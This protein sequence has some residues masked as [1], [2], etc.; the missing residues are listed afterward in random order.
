MLIERRIDNRLTKSGF[1]VLLWCKQCLWCLCLWTKFPA[2]RKQGCEN[3]VS[4]T[5]LMPTC[6]VRDCTTAVIEM[7]NGC[8]VYWTIYIFPACFFYR[9]PDSLS[10]KNVETLLPLESYSATKYILRNVNK[11]RHNPHISI[12]HR[13]PAKVEKQRIQPSNKSACYHHIVLLQRK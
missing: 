12:I 3:K 6:S 5:S 1:S 11:R 8:T 13:V 4:W 7:A 9:A 2:W 10:R